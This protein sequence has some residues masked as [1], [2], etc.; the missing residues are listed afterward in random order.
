MRFWCIFLL[1]VPFGTYGQQV[2]WSGGDKMPLSRIDL[3]IFEEEDESFDINDVSDSLFQSK[4]SQRKLSQINFERSVSVFWIKF[5]IQNHSGDSLLL[6][7]AQALIPEASL[8]FHEENG[9]WAIINSGFTTSI[10]DK[11]IP[12]NFQLF[13]LPSNQTEFYL[14]IQANGAPLPVTL[15]NQDFYT[16]KIAGQKIVYGIYMGIMLFVILLNLFLYVT[17]GR[18]GY[19]HYAF[20][21]FLYATFSAFFEGYILYIFPN[22]DLMYWYTLNPVVNQPNGLLFCI[23]FLDIRK[24]SGKLFISSLV[25]LAYFFSY[26]IWYRFLP[27][28]TEHTITQ[29]HALG[30]ILV[31]ATLG[32]LIGR[33]GNKL[34]YYFS[35]AY[36]VFFVIASIEVI[37]LQTGKPSHIFDLSYVSIA[38]FT[39]V[40]LLLFLLSKRFQ[41][42]KEE[43]EKAKTETQKQLLEQTR[44]NERIV[45]EQNIIL[46]EKVVER[47]SQLKEANE[48]LTTLLETVEDERKKSESLLLN[49]LPSTTARELKELGNAK[50]QNYEM[51][52]VLFTDFENFTRLTTGLP[53]ESLVNDLN[54]CF[55]AFDRIIQKYGIEKIKTIGDAYMAAGGIPIPTAL[56]AL[57]TVRAALEI[58][59]FMHKWN[60]KR[61]DQNILKLN[62]RIGIHSGPVVAGVVGT[63]KFA[64]DVWGDTVNIAARMESNGQIGKV[65][66]SEATYN[67]I[68]DTFK[69]ASRGKIDVKGK[70]QLEMYWVE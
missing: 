18:V 65:N 53:P 13:S 23:F 40:F 49:I 22:I 35:L 9:A 5:S 8:Y 19:L 69:C 64:Y 43:V 12:H 27:L 39:E 52:T 16:K 61:T 2:H 34:G 41:W 48:E 62:I 31:M 51:V 28:L 1:L 55:S 30:G 67:L 46:E 59:D 3:L 38:I 44:E 7:L 24:Y 63:H 15:W 20:L 58:R 47:T 11:P 70:G 4:F 57:D 21:V 14:R 26:I 45:S 50:P 17:L 32:I 25:L 54:D 36:F 42:E 66:V 33:K 60:E 29:L 37:Y 56:H 10:F 68:K 6:E